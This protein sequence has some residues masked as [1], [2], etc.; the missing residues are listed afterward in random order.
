MEKTTEIKLTKAQVKT[1]E[2]FTKLEKE[3]AKIE[4]RIDGILNGKTMQKPITK[5]FEMSDEAGQ[6][7]WNGKL[8]KRKSTLV[9][10]L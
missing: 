10:T 2:T 3:R 1:W 5:A 4:K 8:N 6:E 7:F 9:V